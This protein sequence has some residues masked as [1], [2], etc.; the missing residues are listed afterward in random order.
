MTKY[1]MTYI[2]THSNNFLLDLAISLGIHILRCTDKNMRAWCNWCSMAEFSSACTGSSPVARYCTI[3]I[4][5]MHILLGLFFMIVGICIVVYSSALTDAFWRRDRADKNLGWTT[6]WF[7]SIGFV[8][9][10]IGVIVMFGWGASLSTD[11]TE[12]IP[13]K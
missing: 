11:V 1:N 2:F 12:W 9:I 8:I 7:V 5:H 3:L 13:S 10:I 6:Q 4:N